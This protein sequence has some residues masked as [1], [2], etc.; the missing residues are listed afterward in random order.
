MCFWGEVTWW[1]TGPYHGD[2]SCLDQ[3]LVHAYSTKRLSKDSTSSKYTMF[4]T[5]FSLANV[6]PLISWMLHHFCYDRLRRCSIQPS[7]IGASWGTWKVAS[8]QDSQPCFLPKERLI[9]NGVQHRS[10]VKPKDVM[11]DPRKLI[12]IE[13]HIMVFC[14]LMSEWFSIVFSV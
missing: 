12:C 1:L 7:N 8:F 9:F 11:K 3:H 4:S 5:C 6:F 13:N 2:L 14:T 10:L